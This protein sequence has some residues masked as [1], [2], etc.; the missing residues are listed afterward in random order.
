[1]DE[2]TRKQVLHAISGLLLGLTGYS[3]EK[4]FG[5]ATQILAIVDSASN[6][7]S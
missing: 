4:C 3:Y 5:L 7:K 2:A 6:V 1:M